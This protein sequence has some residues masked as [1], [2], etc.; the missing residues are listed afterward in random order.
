MLLK[1]NE[2]LEIRRK[3]VQSLMPLVNA[4]PKIMAM[5]ELD[6][7][8]LNGRGKDLLDTIEWKIQMY[9]AIIEVCNELV[10]Y[11]FECDE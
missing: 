5:C 1:K 10:G 9:E 2:I 3:A 8:L 6:V 4:Q 7:N 11:N